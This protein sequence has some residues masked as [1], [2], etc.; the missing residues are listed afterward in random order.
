METLISGGSEG[1][2]SVFVDEVIEI[3]HRENRFV[4]LM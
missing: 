4:K 3:S 1:D 2:P